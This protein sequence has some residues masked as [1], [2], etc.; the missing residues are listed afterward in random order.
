MEIEQ[1]I[2]T[3][4]R[5]SHSAEES[6]REA[7]LTAARTLRNGPRSAPRAAGS[8]WSETEDA[9]LCREFDEG[10]G[11]ADMAAQHGRTRAAITLRLVKLGRLDASDV[12]L[13]DR[14]KRL[15]S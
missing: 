2:T 13:R 12:R 6:D 8:R 5:I 14:S 4:E 3:L 11:V 9:Q 1:V 7:L 15:V 10:L